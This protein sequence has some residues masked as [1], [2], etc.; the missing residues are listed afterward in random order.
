ML[1]TRCVFDACCA[2]FAWNMTWLW[3]FTTATLWLIPSF[4]K[5]KHSTHFR[6]LNSKFMRDHSS[7]F[8]FFQMPMFPVSLYFLIFYEPTSTN[9]KNS[10]AGGMYL[11]ALEGGA[12]KCISPLPCCPEI[13]TS[14]LVG[15]IFSKSM[16]EAWF[17]YEKVSNVSVFVFWK[18]VR[19]YWV[20]AFVEAN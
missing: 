9:V 1:I 17:C 6:T 20:L 18:I 19:C 5:V 14:L 3:P 7:T 4:W 16:K 10:F 12:L 8:L 2:M 11:R 13:P 15:D